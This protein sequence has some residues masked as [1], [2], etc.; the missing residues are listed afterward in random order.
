MYLYFKNFN[1]ALTI[2]VNI[3]YSWIHATLETENFY[4]L[5]MFGIFH[6]PSSWLLRIVG[7]SDAVKEINRIYK[8]QHN[9]ID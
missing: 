2:R 9:R 8:Y 5:R 1:R 4:E 6:S 3:R 7:R